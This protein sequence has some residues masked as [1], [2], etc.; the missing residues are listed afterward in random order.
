MRRSQQG[1]T[2]WHVRKEA[3]Y[4]MEFIDRLRIQSHIVSRYQLS[5]DIVHLIIS[6]EAAK[7]QNDRNE[8]LYEDALTIRDIVELLR[9]QDIGPAAYWKMEAYFC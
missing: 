1:D 4:L 8:I 7:G 5:M 6:E 2:R 3:E 9:T